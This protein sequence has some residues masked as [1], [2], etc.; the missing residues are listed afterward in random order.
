M[1][2]EQSKA[3]SYKSQL[4]LTKIILYN[5]LFQ[6]LMNA[7]VYII[8]KLLACYTETVIFSQHF[9]VLILYIEIKKYLAFITSCRWRES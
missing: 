4:I 6:P 2:L 5:L 7:S 9:K 1:V 3:F 8:H